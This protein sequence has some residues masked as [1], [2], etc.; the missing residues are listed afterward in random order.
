MKYQKRFKKHRNSQFRSGHIPHNKGITKNSESNVTSEQPTYVRLSKDDFKL[1]TILSGAG[2]P[3]GL[4]REELNPKRQTMFL[5]PK[6]STPA[7]PILGSVLE[8]LQE[9]PNSEINEEKSYRIYHRGYLL[10]LFNTAFKEH[11][12]ESRN[13]PGDLNWDDAAATKRGLAWQ[14]RLTCLTCGYTSNSQNLYKTIKTSSRGPK[15]ADINYALQVGMHHSGISNVGMCYILNAMSIPAPCSTAMQNSANKVGDMIIKHN[16]EDMQNICKKIKDLNTKSGLPEDYPISVQMDARYNN[17]VYSATGKSPFQ[18]GTQVTQVTVENRTSKK[19]VID[20]TNKGMLCPKGV[21]AENMTGERPCPNHKGCTA[22]LKYTDVIGNEKQWAGESL[23][24]LANDNINVHTIVTDPDSSCYRAGSELYESNKL[25]VSPRHQLDT[26]H[27]S[28][29]QRNFVKKIIFSKNMFPGKNKSEQ[30][31]QQVRFAD[32]L[33]SRCH[34][35]HCSAYEKLAGELPKIR[36]SMT[37]A[38]DAI[39]KCYQRDHTLCRKYSFICKGKI[40]SNWLLHSAYL[41]SDFNIQ[42]LDSDIDKL[43]ECVDFR[44]SG[45][46]INKTQE[47]LN[48]QKTEAVNKAISST[49]PKNK[50]FA[51]N[52][53]ARVHSGV[54][55]VN[56][57]VGDSIVRQLKFV[58]APLAPGILAVQQLQTSQRRAEQQKIANKTP[59]AKRKRYN[60]KKMLYSLHR[61]RDIEK[62]NTYK[63]GLYFEDI[64]NNIPVHHD[65]VM[66]GYSIKKDHLYA[67][68]CQ[69]MPGNYKYINI[70]DS[71]RNYLIMFTLDSVVSAGGYMSLGFY[72]GCIPY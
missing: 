42:P 60:K 66:W 24:R 43:V 36:K 17:P 38:R 22:T 54:S 2:K 52:Y 12:L 21:R 61:A 39:I 34:A 49:A 18:S 31:T 4:K 8:E 35:E 51:R 70:I 7:D 14:E 10:D 27:F 26:R 67:K 15:I 69:K 46:A 65:R 72:S 50:T 56:R 41:S 9:G 13:C 23:V 68:K 57:G 33:A 63:T 30:K 25:K 19:F 48:T 1:D 59:M 62:S 37:Y 64:K 45:S 58:G 47:L 16:K 40:R 28:H 55:G 44:L 5:R 29:N 53:N 6:R 32:D 3:G 11:R 20:I 71:A